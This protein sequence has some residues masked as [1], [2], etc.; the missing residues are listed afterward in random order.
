[1]V[2]NIDGNDFNG[3]FRDDTLL[4]VVV[5]GPV[6]IKKSARPRSSVCS[7]VFV[8]LFQT[9]QDDK[10]NDMFKH[11]LTVFS[12]LSFD[13]LSKEKK[14]KLQFAWKI[15][16]IIDTNQSKN[17]ETV[18]VSLTPIVTD[19]F[20]AAQERGE[21][22]QKVDEDWTYTL[23]TT[24]NAVKERNMLEKIEAGV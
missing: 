15:G 9:T 8:G 24:Q 14:N 10:T 5:Q 11:E 16:K 4:N 21:P 3:D 7:M 23:R 12:A 20:Q 2:N 13:K 18:N 19:D 22:Y 1:M 6:R 17:L